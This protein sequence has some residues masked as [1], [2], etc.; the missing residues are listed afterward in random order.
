MVA[1]EDRRIYLLRH[2][3]TEW[4]RLGKHTSVTDI[5]LTK[6]GRAA[7]QRLRSVLANAPFGLVLTSP[8]RRARDTCELAGLGNAAIVEPDLM[9][10]NY[11]DYEGLTTSEI[12]S[13]R[14]D[15]SL[16]RN[17]CPGGESPEQVA[18][19]AE[20]IISKMQETERHVALFAHGHIFRVLA[21]RWINLPASHGE[22]FLLDTATLSVLGYYYQTP[23]VKIWNAPIARE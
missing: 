15:W 18:S 14:P 16:F 9:E 4:S 20:R 6:N 22:R 8:M 19:R 17:G 12:R 10:W 3:E 21:A 5:S 13:K 1:R 7:A 23:A 2:G 11:G